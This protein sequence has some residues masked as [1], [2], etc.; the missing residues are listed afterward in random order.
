M[1]LPQIL[2]DAGREH[3]NRNASVCHLDM[4]VPKID[5]SLCWGKRKSQDIHKKGADTEILG[6]HSEP[7]VQKSAEEKPLGDN[8]IAAKAIQLRLK[9]KH[10]EAQKLL[11]EVQNARAEQEKMG[12]AEQEKGERSVNLSNYVSARR[13]TSRSIKRAWKMIVTSISLSIMK[14]RKFRIS[15]QVDD[16]YSCHGAPARKSK[17]KGVEL[18]NESDICQKSTKRIITQQ[19]RCVYCFENPNRP[20]HLVVAIANFTYLMLSQ[21]Q[22]VAPGHCC[23]VT[24]QHELGSRM[25]YDNVWEEIRNFKKCLI[26][27]FAKQDKE[28]IFLETVMGLAQQRCH[29][30]IEC[31]PLPRDIAKAAPLY[32]KKAIDEA[33]DEWSQHN[34]K[35]LIDTI[36][37]GLRSSIPEHFPYF[38]V[39]FGLKRGFVHVIDDE[40]QFK[41]SFGLNVLRGMLQTQDEDMYRHRRYESI[42]VQRQAVA[43]FYPLIGVDSWSSHKMITKWGIVHVIDDERRFKSS[44]SLNVVTGML[45]AQDDVSHRRRYESIEVQMQA[46]AAFAREQ[47]MRSKKRRGKVVEICGGVKGSTAVWE[48]KGRFS[49][50]GGSSRR[51][52]AV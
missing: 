39:E 37:K 5:D 15:T 33:E 28:V 41:S 45:R 40:T 30:F 6:S 16:E 22:P 31:I 18:N 17:R 20:K 11:K 35:K 50:V 24:L 27:M 48:N 46:V 26:L 38:H 19:E 49:I 4:R 36:D 10:D 1:H 2:E 14:N 12:K 43:A 51:M 3:C 47:T 44:F 42:E 21:F 23:I 8:R 13:Y 25:V 52:E 34:A 9:G 29:C 32:F 7:A